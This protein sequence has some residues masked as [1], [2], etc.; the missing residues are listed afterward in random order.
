MLRHEAG[1]GKPQLVVIDWGMVRRLTP[2]FRRAYCV[3]W[4]SF[5]EQDAALG[6]KAVLALGLQGEAYEALSL[7]LTHRSASGST[8]LGGQ[9]PE[10]ERAR[11][12]T[13]YKAVTAGDINAFLQSLPRDFLFV[14]RNTGIVRSL[15]LSLGGT[16]RERFR[17][18]GRSALRG[19]A[20]TRALG[21]R[22]LL[23]PP[24]HLRGSQT[25]F[26]TDAAAEDEAD[27]VDLLETL[28]KALFS[29]PPRKPATYLTM[30]L[31]PSVHGTSTESETKEGRQPLFP[32]FTAGWEGYFLELRFWLADL[33]LGLVV[34]HVDAGAESPRKNTG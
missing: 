1:S 2:T 26:V 19:L 18:S 8:A 15:N 31:H 29:S 20:L 21:E 5:L 12:K 3:L 32:W 30:L 22:D 23:P 24:A 14:S 6:E 7:M 28:K 17:A 16:S 9:M 4:Q 10:E 34:A 13:K 27:S 25:Q 33:A 11:M